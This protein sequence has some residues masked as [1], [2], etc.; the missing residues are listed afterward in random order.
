M[1]FPEL[2][3]ELGEFPEEGISGR[4]HLLDFYL[5]EIAGFVALPGFV[6]LV[7]QLPHQ[8]DRRNGLRG[9]RKAPAKSNKTVMD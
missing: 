9:R 1:L 2:P 4:L 6:P 8:F 5:P 7:R 3:A